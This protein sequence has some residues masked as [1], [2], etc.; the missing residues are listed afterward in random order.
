M[1]TLRTWRIPPKWRPLCFAIRLA[2]N[3][4]VQILIRHACD[5]TCLRRG[6][7]AR[8][9][10]LPPSAANPGIAEQRRA[11]HSAGAC[12]GLFKTLSGRVKQ[13]QPI[14]TRFLCPSSSTPVVGLASFEEF[15]SRHFTIVLRMRRCRTNS[16]G[17]VE[18]V[19]IALPPS[20]L[21][22]PRGRRTGDFINSRQLNLLMS[23]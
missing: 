13:R 1:N 10:L 7:S 9:R 19:G 12:G 3:A 4:L 17:L 6:S 21:P 14:S 23:S 8:L 18:K 22:S 11:V 5:P 15:A 20:P 2:K 16:G